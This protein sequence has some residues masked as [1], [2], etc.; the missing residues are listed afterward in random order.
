MSDATRELECLA[1]TD[2]AT[3]ARSP[4]GAWWAKDCGGALSRAEAARL[5]CED[6]DLVGSTP[7]AILEFILEKRPG[8][9]VVLRTGREA[10]VV[11][12]TRMEPAAL[13]VA[14]E[15]DGEPPVRLIAAHGQLAKVHAVNLL[16]AHRELLAGD[17]LIVMAADEPHK[18]S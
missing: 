12:R 18:Q 11:A 16:L 1:E 3:F 8:R 17:R 15:R 13:V 2:G 9:S 5:Y 7:E 4:G 14:F 10:L 6:K